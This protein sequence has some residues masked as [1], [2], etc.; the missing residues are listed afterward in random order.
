MNVVGTD[1]GM[2]SVFGEN[3]RYR[4]VRAYLFEAKKALNYGTAY[5]NE[6]IE[7]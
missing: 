5:C 4:I 2:W 1:A 6:Y 3:P 7:W